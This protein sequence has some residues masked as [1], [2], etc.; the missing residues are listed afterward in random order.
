[1][2]MRATVPKAQVQ[3]TCWVPG[4]AAAEEEEEACCAF[5]LFSDLQ[6]RSG[7]RESCSVPKA[8]Q[9]PHCWPTQVWLYSLLRP[10]AR[11]GSSTRTSQNSRWPWRGKAKTWTLMSTGSAG[12]SG[13]AK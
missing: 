2:A 8:T 4:L 11:R 5:W 6:K 1:M 3:A 12:R 10:L 9:D 13:R 7:G